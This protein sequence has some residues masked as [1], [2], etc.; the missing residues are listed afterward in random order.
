MKTLLLPWCVWIAVFTPAALAPAGTAA[1]QA[2]P[3]YARQ[4]GPSGCTLAP[5]PAACRVANAVAGG[6]RYLGSGTLVDCDERFGLVV[7][8][9]HLFR[10]GAGTISVTFPDGQS[11]AA[12]LVHSD[13]TWDL[14]ALLIARPNVEPVA[15]APAHPRQGEAVWS[16]GFGP[17]GRYACNAG[18]VTGYVRAGAAA[19]SE[20]LE[21]TGSA[22]EGDSGGPVF[23]QQGELVAVLW[24]T[25]GRTVGG[26]YCGRVDRFLAET[27]RYLLPWNAKNDPA[28]RPPQPIVVPGGADVSRVEAKLDRIADL[29]AEL[30]K[31]P[32]ADGREKPVA[33]LP[34][35][36]PSPAETPKPADKPDP[37]LT[38]LPAVVQKLAGDVETLPERFQAR[39]DKVKAEGAETTREVARAYVKDLLAEKL[40]DGTL[41]LT[42]GKLLGGA[43]GLSAPLA[44]AVAL[45]AWLLSR[46]IGAKVQ[47]GDPLLVERLGT[48]LGAKIDDLRGRLRGGTTSDTAK[49][50]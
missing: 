43:L 13:A 48:L 45:G 6:A 9:Q 34:R 16:C 38:A 3:G 30:G 31:S 2:T 24:G 12:R 7:T 14:A 39:I 10:G 22:R 15:I 8:C 25:D 36:E 11:S 27:G 44:A 17:D 29:L 33:P 42:A 4:C 18:R 28:N 46:R 40:S 26:T 19:T 50:P 1:A 23:N 32:P 41:G 49:E 35:Q 21:L 37:G 20:T 47:S 5:N